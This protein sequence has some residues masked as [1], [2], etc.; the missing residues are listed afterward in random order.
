M[1]FTNCLHNLKKSLEEIKP[2]MKFEDRSQKYC[3]QKLYAQ[4][5]CRSESLSAEVRADASAEA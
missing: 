5:V 1:Y 2:A 4:K 3:E